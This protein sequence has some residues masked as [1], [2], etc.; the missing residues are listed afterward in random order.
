LKRSDNA[1]LNK[2]IYQLE[3]E[4]DELNSKCQE[5]LALI[6][7]LSTFT[8]ND[9]SAENDTYLGCDLCMAAKELGYSY[10]PHC[11]KKM[12]YT[13]KRTASSPEKKRTSEKKL[14][15]TK[16]EGNCLTIV[17][18]NGFNEK[19]VVIPA[20]IDNIP[21]IGIGEG[22]FE[23][24]NSLEEVVFEEGCRYI[25]KDSFARCEWLKKVELPITLEE[26]G[27]CAFISCKRLES[28][29]IP[30]GVSVIG[31][32]AFC[33]CK[34]LNKVALP[35]NLKTVSGSMF[36]HSGI[37]EICIPQSVE[38]IGSYAFEDTLIEE[39]ELPKKLKYIRDKAFAIQNLRRITMYD[40]ISYIDGDI[41]KDLGLRPQIK[42]NVTV[43]CVA[44]S[45]AHMYAR[46][47]NIR[48]V[49][50]EE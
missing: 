41:F 26:I 48:C 12:E 15:I 11:G 18:Y 29:H 17:Q 25:G 31:S 10:C 5:Y 14:F 6:G 45:Y 36:A 39:I 19:S 30:E 4:V 32:L 2:R 35:N 21:V 49:E 46:K 38:D 20:Q 7:K 37:K 9:L 33:G 23:R 16:K 1:E 24:C 34:M 47:N 3:K 13:I 50:I 42:P 40:N 28:I 27:D 22:V 44:G 8:G 43:Y